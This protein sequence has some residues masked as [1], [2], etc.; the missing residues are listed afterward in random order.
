MQKFERPMMVLCVAYAIMMAV[1]GWRTAVLLHGQIAPVLICAIASLFLVVSMIGWW[2]HKLMWVAGGQI[3]C[4]I[5]FPTPYGMTVMIAGFVVF[6]LAV[7]LRLFE[8]IDGNGS[9][10]EESSHKR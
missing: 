1:L 8:M 9:S 10:S 5:L 6:M 4:S 3:G 7:G 2:K